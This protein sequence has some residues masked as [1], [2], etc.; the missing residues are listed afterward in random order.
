MADPGPA[1]PVPPAGDTLPGA[2]PPKKKGGLGCLG[3]LAIVAGIFAVL[4]LIL[5]IMIWQAVSWVKN[6]PESSIMSMEP[7]KL[8]EGEQEDV[9]RVVNSLDTAKKKK[10]NFDESVTTNVINGVLDWVIKEEKKKPNPNPETWVRARATFNGPL[11]RIRAT[12]PFK[13][14]DSNS[15][16]EGLFINMDMDVDVEIIDG[17]V[18]KLDVR[19]VT[20][21][22]KEAPMLA[23][24]MINAYTVGIREATR[25]AKADPNQEN[26]LKL[27]KVLKR[28]GSGKDDDR[29]RIVLD[30]NQME[31]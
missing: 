6:A 9:E 20:L 25:Q 2:A 11:L 5:G 10:Q 4:L 8:S 26:P 16:K 15:V 29:L 19:K 23:R 14:K 31:D 28:E 22:G 24:A 21:G 27:I 30:G 17:E 7:V 3:I 12:I 18:T 13:D 1:A